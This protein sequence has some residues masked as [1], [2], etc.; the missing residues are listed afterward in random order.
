MEISFG[1]IMPLQLESTRNIVY[2]ENSTERGQEK[3]IET[4]Q[5]SVKVSHFLVKLEHTLLMFEGN[6]TGDVSRRAHLPEGGN[7]PER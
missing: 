3:I 7:I 2:V 1:D 6:C 5:S 4:A